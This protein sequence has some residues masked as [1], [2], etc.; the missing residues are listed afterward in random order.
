MFVCKKGFEVKVLCSNFHYI[1]TLDKDGTPNC[2]ISA[3][4]K[5][6]ELAQHDLHF[7]T[8]THR[9]CCEND[10]CSGELGCKLEEVK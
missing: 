8:F 4:Y 6:A 3:Y 5:N 2:R 9:L 10:F 1:G 7:Q